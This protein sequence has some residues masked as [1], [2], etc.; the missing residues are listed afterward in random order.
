ML[1]QL[2]PMLKSRERERESCECLH[3]RTSCR[4]KERIPVNKRIGERVE[5]TMSKRRIRASRPETCYNPPKYFDAR[6]ISRRDSLVERVKIHI[7]PIVIS[8]H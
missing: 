4:V 6:E 3:I 1:R 7:S 8:E 5:T 2:R